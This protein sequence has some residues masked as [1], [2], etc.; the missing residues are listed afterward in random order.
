M[1]R[2]DIESEVSDLAIIDQI[3]A[4]KH[5]HF[6][7]L[8]RRYNQR[9]FRII[10]IYVRDETDVEDLMQETY[11]SC[12]EHLRGFNRKAS[13]ATWITRIGINKALMHLRERKKVSAFFQPVSDYIHLNN[14]FM[15]TSINP[16]EK[17]ISLE[18]KLQLERLI[19]ALPVKY[20]EVFML[21]HFNQM[22]SMDI[23]SCLDITEE[24][25]RTRLHRARLLLKNRLVPA[26]HQNALFEFGNERCDGITYRV[27]QIIRQLNMPAI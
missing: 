3:L 1:N 14:P 18:T 13:F 9:L 5:Q 19:D 26:I 23:A 2:V 20:R 27:M 25:V 6:E 17:M 7:L 8:I 4:G 21:W 10:R 15:E 12:F 24:N 16:E 11:L 22:K